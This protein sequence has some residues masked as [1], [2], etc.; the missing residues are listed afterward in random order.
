MPLSLRLSAVPA[1][2][3]RLHRR[4]FKWSLAILLQ[5]KSDRVALVDSTQR[6][7]FQLA[8]AAAAAD[9]PQST[10]LALTLLL[11]RVVAVAVQATRVQP[12][13]RAAQP[14][15]LLATPAATVAVLLWVD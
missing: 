14:E 15:Q 7:V 9:F 10:F 12:A 8:Q 5:S 11:R 2:E 6:A 1:A 13:E 3:A 4:P